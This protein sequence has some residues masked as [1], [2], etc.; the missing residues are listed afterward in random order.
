MSRASSLGIVSTSRG[1]RPGFDSWQRKK[2]I[3]PL[4]HR[5]QTG[6][7][8]HPASYPVGIR[9]SFSGVKRPRREADHSPPSGTEVKNAWGYIFTPPIR[10]HGVVLNEKAAQGQLYLYSCRYLISLLAS[11]VSF[12]LVDSL[13]TI[14]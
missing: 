5:V 9:G 3:L 4:R 6:S 7:M 12:L 2:G 8:A 13:N 14:S 10:L 1:G 11:F